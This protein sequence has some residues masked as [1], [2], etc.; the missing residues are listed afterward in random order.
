MRGGALPLFFSNTGRAPRH[1]RQSRSYHWREQSFAH[2]GVRHALLPPAVDGSS[3]PCGAELF[4]FSPLIGTQQA[5]CGKPV[6]RLDPRWRGMLLEPRCGTPWVFIRDQRNLVVHRIR[7]NVMQSGK[8][9]IFRDDVGFQKVVPNLACGR[10]VLSI[11]PLCGNGMEFPKHRAQG[12]RSSW[13]G[14]RDEVIVVRKNRPSLQT[15]LELC[16]R[17]QQEIMKVAKP[18]GS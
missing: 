9:G 18:V 13:R 5:V 11:Q 8:M 16:D 15:P 14:F 12:I 10:S 3:A 6:N 1:I 4:F 17:A 2:S 7:M